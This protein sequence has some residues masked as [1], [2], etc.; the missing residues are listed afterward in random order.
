MKWSDAYSGAEMPSLEQ[1]STFVA[2]PL[3]DEL[4]VY[5]QSNY[6]ILP[7]VEYST[8]S[9]AP[10]WNIK[11]RKSGRALCTLYP[12]DGFFTCLVTVG[13]REATEAEL[14]LPSC[15]ERV[16]QIYGNAKPLNGARWLMIPVTSSAILE[17]VKRL[18]ALRIQKRRC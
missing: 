14:L 1:I 12:D 11:Y 13:N 10:G 4:C 8:C 7:R 3:W 2:S 15:S 18:V 16:G 6:D 9:G 5:L 17:D